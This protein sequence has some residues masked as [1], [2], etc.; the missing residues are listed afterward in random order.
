VTSRPDGLS[1]KPEPL[2]EFGRIRRFFAPLATSAG[3]LG[4]RDDAAILDLAPGQQLVVTTDALVEG[5]HFLS[6]DPPA[7]IAAK[8][9]RTNLSDL[10]AKAARPLGYLLTLSLPRSRGDAWV[11]AFASGLA[12]DQA[13]YS[14]TLL[15]GDSVSTEGPVTVSITAFGVVEAGR[16]VLRSGAR[17][18]DVIMVTG[19]IGDAALG[20]LAATWRLEGQSPADTAW[21]ADRYRLPQPRC[22]IGVALGPHVNAMMDISDGLV[23]DLGH[24][25]EASGV[26]AVLESARLPLS[27]AAAAVIADHPQLFTSCLAGGDD[28]EL[29]FAADPAKVA[30]IA[31]LAQQFGVKVTVVG[32]LEAQRADVS[33]VRVVDADGQPVEIAEPGWRHS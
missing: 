25:A 7:L 32:Q 23:A 14:V 18:G 1:D 21:L 30:M 19:T 31:V 33:Q 29:L 8:A 5:V 22:G 2:G 10:A 16:A 13:E 9:L 28:Y 27:D 26:D 15:G 17:A 6:A 20:L 11:E 24:L 4:L 3:A 12:R